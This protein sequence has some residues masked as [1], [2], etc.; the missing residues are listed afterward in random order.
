VKYFSVLAAEISD[1]GLVVQLSSSLHF[2]KSTEI[3]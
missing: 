2:I 1:N 3:H